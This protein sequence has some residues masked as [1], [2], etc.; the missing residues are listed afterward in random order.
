MTPAQR[1]G[2][3]FI[4]LCI[5]STVTGQLLVK[6]GMTQVGKAPANSSDLPMFLLKALF[7]PAVFASLVCALFAALCW[8]GAMTRCDLSFGYPFMSLAIVL[9]LALSP[10]CFGEHVSGRQWLG[11]GFVC[12]GL[13]VSSRPG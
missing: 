1:S 7:S 6:Y 8:M 4:F 3:I 2:L 11:V 10:V 9:V 12:L 13:W 5:A